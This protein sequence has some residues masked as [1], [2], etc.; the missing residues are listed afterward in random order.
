MGN[1]E[2]DIVFE[3]TNNL[4]YSGQDV[5]G[6]L[7][8]HLKGTLKISVVSISLVGVGRTSWRDI[9]SDKIFES[10]ETYIDKSLDM[11]SM[12][13]ATV[14]NPGDFK[15]SFSFQLPKNLPSSYEGDYGYVRYK[16]STSIQF[17]IAPGS[18]SLTSFKS[19]TVLES[20]SVNDLIKNPEGGI[21]REGSFDFGCFLSKGKVTG[22]I[23]VSNA[24]CQVWTSLPVNIRV[25]N[26][27]KKK[28]PISLLFLQE[29][30]FQS[31][32]KYEP[33]AAAKISTKVVKSVTL[34]Y[35]T[36][37]NSE[38]KQISIEIPFDLP[39]TSK[40][41]NSLIA[42]YYKLKL[43]FGNQYE[44]VIPIFVGTTPD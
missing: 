20:V 28:I 27:S 15:I 26:G 38:T 36:S 9:Q 22:S 16:V 1:I 32:S 25:I 17:G 31:K 30:R 21:C 37:K 18:Q 42:T 8:I 12:I 29:A 11:T 6:Y 40:L 3:R 5:S 24:G 35:V 2:V 44:I 10:T 34:D 14:L 7:M 23:A 39:P 41:Q 33:D 43:D 19:L 13:P 4:Y